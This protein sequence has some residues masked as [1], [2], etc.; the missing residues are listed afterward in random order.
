[1]KRMI[2][3]LS[4]CSLAVKPPG[5]ESEA[6]VMTVRLRK[7]RLLCMVSAPLLHVTERQSHFTEWARPF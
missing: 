3:G 1:M 7:S 2:L 4:F 6:A 5:T